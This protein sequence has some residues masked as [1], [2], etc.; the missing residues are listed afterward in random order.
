LPIQHRYRTPKQS[1]GNRRNFWHGTAFF[2]KIERAF[3]WGNHK[4][5]TSWQ[6]NNITTLQRERRLCTGLPSQHHD[7]TEVL[8]DL[9]QQVPMTS[10]QNSF[11]NERKLQICL[12]K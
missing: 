7:T 2:P 12:V 3:T 10:F 8:T 4:N 9:I 1:F 6:Q 11:S 5:V